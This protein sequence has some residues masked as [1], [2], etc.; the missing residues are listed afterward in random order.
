M[1]NVWSSITLSPKDSWSRPDQFIIALLILW[2]ERKADQ[3]WCVPVEIADIYGF[4]SAAMSA[5]WVRPTIEKAV[6]WTE[7]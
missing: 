2:I 5:P 4:A 6:E 3:S 7:D 1:H